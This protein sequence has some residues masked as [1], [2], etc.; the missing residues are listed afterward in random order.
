M[1]TNS[2]I[3]ES[4]V[5]TNLLQSGGKLPDCGLRLH[6]RRLAAQAEVR[7]MAVEIC[8]FLQHSFPEFF[9][10]LEMGNFLSRNI[11]GFAGPGVSS[12]SSGTIDYME[13]SEATDLDPIPVLEAFGYGVQDNLN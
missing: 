7:K 13:G 10:R 4:T 5:Q 1:S 9:A 8:S 11:Y 6:D 2:P 3:N 12:H